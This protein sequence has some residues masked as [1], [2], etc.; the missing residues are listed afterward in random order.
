MAD[1]HRQ[2]WDP[3]TLLD[4]LEGDITDWDY[5]Q[6]LRT[7]EHRTGATLGEAESPSRDPVRLAQEPSLAFAPAAFHSARGG[8]QGRMVLSQ[9]FF[10]L[11]GPNGP[12]P[13]HLTEVARRRSMARTRPFSDFANVFHHRL[14]SFVYRAWA[15]TRPAVRQDHPE[16][17]A[18]WHWIGA[19]AGFGVDAMRDSQESPDSVR[20]GVAG[21]LLSSARP[22]EGIERMIGASLGAK[23]WVEEFLGEWIEIPAEERGALGSKNRRRLGKNFA[24]GARSWQRGNRVRLNVGP[25]SLA[26]YREYL[27]GG[28]RATRLASL[29]DEYW[30]KSLT[31]DAVVTLRE[32]EVPPLALEK[33][34]ARL[35]Q[36]SWSGR[37]GTPKENSDRPV[38]GVRITSNSTEFNRPEAMSAGSK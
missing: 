4:Q 31:W 12:L 33:G 11:F 26:E 15:G 27:P 3:L 8:H 23:A 5:F 20:L 38:V 18:Y 35:G 30:G 22:P 7:I 37:G 13:T 1:E 28:P 21:W 36:T 25:V 24:I 10:G 19:L 6:L 16:S 9:N 29:V 32:D 2:S 17:D 14:L 34:G